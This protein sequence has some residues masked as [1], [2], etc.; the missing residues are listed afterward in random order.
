MT[1]MR[2]KIII[3]AFIALASIIAGLLVHQSTVDLD[4]TEDLKKLNSV[5]EL[6]MIH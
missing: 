3:V 1:F 4:N 2:L 6:F 5:S